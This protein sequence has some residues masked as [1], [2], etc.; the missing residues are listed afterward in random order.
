MSK[1]IV[2]DFGGKPSAVHG[3]MHDLLVSIL[4]PAWFPAWSDFQSFSRTFR[5]TCK[6]DLHLLTKSSTGHT[7]LR[8]TTRVC[9]TSVGYR[10]HLCVFFV[11]GLPLECVLTAQAELGLRA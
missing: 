2:P 3:K 7:G 4:S 10:E 8:K 5:L 6:K 11:P 1:H 9:S